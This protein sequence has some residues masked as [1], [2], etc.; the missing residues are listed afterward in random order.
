MSWVPLA[1]VNRK[2]DAEPPRKLTS[3]EIHDILSAVPEPRTADP[4]TA[5]LVVQE[6]RK[7][8]HKKLRSL[9][10]VPKAI[11]EL[12]RRL[13]KTHWNSQA[14][15]GSSVGLTS[16]EA[17]GSTA[18][19]TTL[20]TF[21]T[22]GSSKN[23]THGNAALSNFIYARAEPPGAMLT[24]HFH[25][26]HMTPKEILT[27]K[28]P[29]INSCYI[30]DLLVGHQMIAVQ[31]EQ[32]MTERFPWLKQAAYLQ[33]RSAILPTSSAIYSYTVLELKI[34]VTKMIK[35]RVTMSRLSAL[36][37]SERPQSSVLCIYSTLEEGTIILVP[38]PPNFVGPDFI[39]ELDFYRVSVLPELEKRRV[40]G[41]EGVS[42]FRTITRSVASYIKK[43]VLI[44]ADHHRYPS[45]RGRREKFWEVF[46]DDEMHKQTG[47]G[48]ED[49]LTLMGLCGIPRS[50]FSLLESPTRENPYVEVSYLVMLPAES[51]SG[52]R[53]IINRKVDAAQKEYDEQL[54]RIA[55]EVIKYAPG[56]REHRAEM[57]AYNNYPYPPILRA[58]YFTFA[59]ALGDKI[60][61]LY[62]L[63]GIDRRHSY[64][65]NIHMINGTLGIEAMATFYTKGLYK[66]I[67]DAGNKVHAA[68]LITPTDCIAST[69]RPRGVRFTGLVARQPN[70]HMSNATVQKA[71]EIFTKSAA[72]GGFESVK[73]ASAA[74]SMGVT[75][76][77]GDGMNP[78]AQIFVNK[79][80]VEE[81]VIEDAVYTAH[82]KDPRTEELREQFLEKRRQHNYQLNLHVDENSEIKPF[83]MEGMVTLPQTGVFLGAIKT[84]VKPIVSKGLK[85]PGPMVIATFNIAS[86]P[87]QVLNNFLR[88]HVVQQKKREGEINYQEFLAVSER[89]LDYKIPS[90]VE[91]KNLVAYLQ[92]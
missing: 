91:L 72:F 90:L 79:N 69:G 25:D 55:T 62:M 47:I 18:T 54:N 12:K 74:V 73:N 20:N 86:N 40:R 37:E 82:E 5:K 10:I 6:T 32:Y 30:K 53:D 56:S 65:N 78:V 2:F 9:S 42:D 77:N 63:R 19:Q 92:R 3:E 21:H 11:P 43:Q 1:G 33:Q 16:S 89:P 4:F 58:A 36:L 75:V 44:D 46:L 31:S 70:G 57:R 71:M 81:M 39:T 15:P 28:M 60:K 24:I 67:T 41:I 23:I 38:R 64:S 51:T 59:E 48:H 80:G 87:L 50:S 27:Q 76:S 84:K 45:I 52:P 26:K 83:V 17:I 88:R 29:L 8:M 13:I 14:I 66:I 68:N 61:E 22:S 35:H 49:L 7:D 85:F 34:N